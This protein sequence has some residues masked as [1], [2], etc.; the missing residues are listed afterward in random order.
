MTLRT[1]SHSS[2]AVTGLITGVQPVHFLPNAEVVIDDRIATGEPRKVAAGNPD[3]T[4]AAAPLSRSQ[5]RSAMRC[6]RG[7]VGRS[8]Q[9]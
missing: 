5:T 3:K 9:Q 8:N 2:D 6:R 4:L 1:P 7:R